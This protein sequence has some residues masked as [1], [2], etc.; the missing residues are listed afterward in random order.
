MSG[1]LNAAAMGLGIAVLGFAVY[2]YMKTTGAVSS[3]T[4]GAA[5]AATPNAGA[6][7]QNMTFPLGTATGGTNNVGLSNVYSSTAWNPDAL[8]ALIGQDTLASM[9]AAGQSTVNAWGFHL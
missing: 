2:E 1:K 6:V 8:S 9:G 7:W 4:A 3:Q 5:V